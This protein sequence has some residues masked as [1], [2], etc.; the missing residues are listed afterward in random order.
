MN[1]ELSD[2]EK[3]LYNKSLDRNTVEAKKLNTFLKLHT[4]MYE[5]GNYQNYLDSQAETKKKIENYKA[6]LENVEFI[7][8]DA[9]DKL[10]NGV[11]PIEVE[12]GK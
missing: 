2:D 5:E 1:R 3:R 11:A 8:K 9:T 10:T 12:G 6:E 4:L 7:I